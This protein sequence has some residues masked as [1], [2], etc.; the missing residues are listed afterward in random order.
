MFGV[1]CTSSHDNTSPRAS[2]TKQE[3]YRYVTL[4]DL[5]IESPQIRHI[6][7]RNELHP[8]GLPG[9]GYKISNLDTSLET[10]C[11]LPGIQGIGYEEVQRT[12]SR[13][14]W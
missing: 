2:N 9:L 6:H 1:K 11:K 8:S 3:K 14:E 13:K 4:T 7:H 10:P 5:D 12:S